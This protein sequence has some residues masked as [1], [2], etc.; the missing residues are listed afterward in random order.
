MVKFFGKGVGIA[1]SFLA[2]IIIT[3]VIIND[4]S[5][6]VEITGGTAIETKILASCLQEKNGKVYGSLNC[7]SCKEQKELFSEE[8]LDKIYVECGYLGNF[9]KKCQDLGITKDLTWVINNKQYPG[10]K[11]ESELRA[12]TNC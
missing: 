12:L 7:A 2:V 3:A 5:P 9:V 4:S 8:E 11:T 1:L 10:L 6:E